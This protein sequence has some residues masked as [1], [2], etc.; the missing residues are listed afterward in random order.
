MTVTTWQQLYATELQGVW[1]QW[2][3]PAVFLVFLAARGQAAGG[4]APSAARFVFAYSIVFA[5]ETMVDPFAG[6][7]LLRWLG[8][9]AGNTQTAVMVLFVL[10]GDFRVFLLALV[11]G[12]QDGGGR[13]RE[14]EVITACGWTLL[15]PLVAVAGEAAVRAV[16]ANPPEQ[17]IWIVY[18]TAFV[19]MALVWR[20]VIVPAR[21]RSGDAA[22]RAYLQTVWLYVAVYYALWALAD[23]VIVAG[24][25]GGWALRLVPNQLYYA[26]Y[27]PFIY[28]RFFSPRYAATSSSAHAV[29]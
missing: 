22:L 7:P 24:M 15:V 17:S 21:V 1:A 10:L 19:A 28:W 3:V 16:M 26:W 9:A 27:V 14:R 20:Q 12:A 2:L 8:V 25:D 5:L 4:I 13:L 23:V 6:G 11:L 18:E 29:R